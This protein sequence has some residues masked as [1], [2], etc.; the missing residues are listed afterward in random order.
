[1]FLKNSI[2]LFSTNC[3]KR[4][5]TVFVYPSIS[6]THHMTTYAEHT[7]THTRT[8]IIVIYAHATQ[9][10]WL[11]RDDRIPQHCRTHSPHRLIE[12]LLTTASRSQLVFANEWDTGRR[13]QSA[14]V[15]NAE[16]T[17]HQINS[18]N[19]CLFFLFCSYM[20]SMSLQASFIK[21]EEARLWRD[22]LQTSET[23][24]LRKETRL[25]CI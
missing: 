16:T 19:L 22:N 7:H 12:R 24:I 5:L 3:C 8:N 18:R 21:L 15:A 20:F 17:V 25:N 1:V 4:G 23:R 6:C 14:P 2:T 13:H 9:V 10:Q 11:S